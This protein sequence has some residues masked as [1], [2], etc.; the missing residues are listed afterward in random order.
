MPTSKSLTHRYLIASALVKQPITIYAINSSQDV[1]ATI[2][3]LRSLGVEITAKTD[4][5]T[6]DGSTLFTLRRVIEAKSSASTLRFLL[7]IG[8][9]Q[10][11][12]I[13]FIGTQQLFDRPLSIYQD[14]WSNQGLQWHQEINKLT[15]CG[16]IRPSNFT[17]PGNISSQFISG[18]LFILPLL[19]KDSTISFSTPIESK[20]Y[21]NLT[22][23]VLNNYSIKTHWQKDK[24]I[25]PG[26]QVYRPFM[27]TIEA[28]YSQAANFLVLS[29]INHPF[30][31]TNLSIDSLQPD[32][33]ILKILAERNIQKLSDQHNN[34]IVD[35]QNCPDLVPILCV[36]A[37]CS[38]D[39]TILVNTRRLVYKESN[40]LLAMQT[41]FSKLGIIIEVND[42][43]AII[44]PWNRQNDENIQLNSHD[45]HRIAMSLSIIA[46]IARHPIIL[47]KAEAIE[48]SYPNF[49]LD[50]QSLGINIDYL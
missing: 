2:D 4:S 8:A 28:D 36:L 13:T 22:Q 19:K 26:N 20:G 21:I 16:Q 23:K 27:P 15:T 33:A 9:L 18:L 5:L 47:I 14:I 31:I 29:S 46:S 6:V 49:Y 48:K 44:Y 50:L 24:L 41:E 34:N 1:Q 42:N 45:D 11:Q 37:A 17:I 10:D 39:T 38:K 43:D 3:G 40:R 7:A 32:I 25:I 12:P 35:C 30:E